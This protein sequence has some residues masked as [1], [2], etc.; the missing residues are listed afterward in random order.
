MLIGSKKMKQLIKLVVLV[1]FVVALTG[2][3]KQTKVET[4]P[5]SKEQVKQIE[6]DDVK[7]VPFAIF[8]F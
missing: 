6:N 1:A 7:V 3:S 8:R 5:W 4:P 2:C